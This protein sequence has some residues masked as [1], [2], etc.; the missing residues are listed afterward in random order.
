MSL[1][2]GTT[3]A[4]LARSLCIQY[5]EK[6]AILLELNFDTGIKARCNYMYLYCMPVFI[7]HFVL[8]SIIIIRI[9][10]WLRYVVAR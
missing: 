8:C 9:H 4:S 2:P 3:N 5:T 1:S 6:V 7:L 10:G